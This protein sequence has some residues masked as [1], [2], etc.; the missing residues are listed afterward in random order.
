MS[1]PILRGNAQAPKQYET[2]PYA[3]EKKCLNRHEA[4]AKLQT[5]IP[6]Q[7]E[8]HKLQ[9]ALLR[10][11]GIAHIHLSNNTSYKV[12]TSPHQN[13][14]LGGFGTSEH[15]AIG[16]EVK[17]QGL[18]QDTPL[19]VKGV[20]HIQFAHIIALAGDFY[21]VPGEAISLP[22][23]DDDQKTK[24]FEN[25]FQTLAKADNNEVRKLLI[26]IKDECSQVKHSSLPHHC[27]S[28]QMIEGNDAKN[29]IKKDLKAL[30]YDNS[31]HFSNNARDAYR[32]GHTY[33][34]KMAREAGLKQDLEGL[35][36]AYALDAFA[37]HFLTDLFAAGHIRNQR[38]ELEL[39]LISEL[40]FSAEKAKPLAGILTGAQH[41][42]DGNEGLNVM[43]ENGDLWRAYGDGCFF[44][45]KCKDNKEKVIAATQQSVDEI[46][47]AYLQP[48]E[49]PEEFV[50]QLLPRAT[51]LNPL[52]IYTVE[53]DAKALFLNVRGK[54]IAIKTQLD[55][56]TKGISQALRYLPQNY[57]DGLVKNIEIEIPPS[58]T[59]YISPKIERFTQP[60]WNMIGTLSKNL[61]KNEFQ[62]IDETII[63]AADEVLASYTNAL[64][65]LNQKVEFDQNFPHLHWANILQN[66]HT[67]HSKINSS[68]FEYKHFYSTLNEDQ[69]VE[70]ENSIYKV[71]FSVA[72]TISDDDVESVLACYKLKL[73]NS[74]TSL[75]IKLASTLWL[76][77]M[78]NYQVNIFKLYFALR[79]KREGKIVNEKFIILMPNIDLVLMKQ[80]E[81]N[82]EFID[83]TLIDKSEK[84]LS[85]QLKKIEIKELA[86]K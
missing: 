68:I 17:L 1:Y 34:L 42:K 2:Y 10:T 41:E 33:A 56:L 36:L 61:D 22:G 39:F 7:E 86:F 4:K 27:Y 24:R 69:L 44:T 31:D 60:L 5:L 51:E 71:A 85:L 49:P 77:Q 35:K 83:I 23:G 57:M 47:Q 55:Y 79:L 29:K 15:V 37:C 67:P 78:L 74:K 20:V 21:G 12:Y 73:E 30:L 16:E 53:N 43:N 28:S 13:D 82:K 6:G 25:A 62:A 52:P 11:H 65:I 8:H 26:E 50:Y 40:K 48:Q 19:M 3:E 76:Q 66:L 63:Q 9:N 70:L 46:Y 81:K 80:V 45:P 75:E 38:G 32:I 14:L 54:K 64:K 59:N 58:D 72:S 18:P 84:Y